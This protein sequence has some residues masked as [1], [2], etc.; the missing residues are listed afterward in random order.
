MNA[1]YLFP[2]VGHLAKGFPLKINKPVCKQNISAG[3]LSSRYSNRVILLSSHL[4]KLRNSSLLRFPTLLGHS[5]VN[6][7]LSNIERQEKVSR[8]IEKEK[9]LQLWPNGLNSI[10]LPKTICLSWL[11]F[12]TLGGTDPL[13][14]LLSVIFHYHSRKYNEKWDGMKLWRFTRKIIDF[15]TNVISYLQKFKSC[16]W[17]RLPISLGIFSLRSLLSVH[18]EKC[19]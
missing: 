11:S 9:K 7:L 3:W 16:S 6:L 13:S 19:Q 15:S 12:P 1:N 4:Q 8:Y 10:L 17:S 14:L 2:K 5:P 18:N